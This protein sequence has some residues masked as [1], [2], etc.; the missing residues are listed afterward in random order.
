MIQCLWSQNVEVKEE[1]QYIGN[2]N[3]DEE[4][5]SVDRASVCDRGKLCEGMGL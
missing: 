2:Y 3:T 5:V 4:T 1:Q